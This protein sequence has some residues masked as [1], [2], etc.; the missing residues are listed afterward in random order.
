MTPIRAFRYDGKS[1]RRAEVVLEFGAGSVCVRGADLEAT[2]PFEQMQVRP[3]IGA[4]TRVVDFADGSRCE[5][6]DVAAFDALH[7]D[8]RAARHVHR[9]ENRLRYALVALAL[10]A[11]AV[12]SVIQYG[13]P[14]AAR[15]AAFSLPSDTEARLGAEILETLDEFLF[16]PSS[17]SV[18]RQQQLRSQFERITRALPDAPAMRFEFRASKSIGA[19]ALALLSGAIVFTDDMVQLAQHDE[20][21]VAVA[22]HE[23]GHVVHRHGLRHVLQDS[24]TALL[25][26]LLSGDVSSSSSMVAALPTFL[27]QMKYS[28]AFETEADDYAYAYLKQ[29]GIPLHRFSD[30]MER[31]ERKDDDKHETPAFLS[32]HP[33]TSERVLRFKQDR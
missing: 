18:E 4:V 12:W 6:A 24:I 13:V 14:V 32:S 5:I 20:E 28:R 8:G 19:N 25:L 26:L 16:R 21:L 15:A 23:V 30:L 2:Y 3:R 27:V 29:A 7:L 10:S 31:L 11:A 22:A 17:L 1:S 9:W 33:A